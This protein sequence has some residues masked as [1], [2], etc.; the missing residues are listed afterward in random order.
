MLENRGISRD[1][2]AMAH[3]ISV[4]RHSASAD[5]PSVHLLSLVW[6]TCDKGQHAEEP[7]EVSV[8]RTVLKRQGAGR[9][10]S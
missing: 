4:V 6:G 2:I 10:A 5:I 3:A 1:T 9:P 8:S 7:Y